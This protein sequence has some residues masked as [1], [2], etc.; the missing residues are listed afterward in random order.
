[1]C[2][3][4]NEQGIRK[5]QSHCCHSQIGC[6]YCHSQSSYHYCHSQIANHYCHSACHKLISHTTKSVTDLRAAFWGLHNPSFSAIKK[7]TKVNKFS[8]NSWTW[9]ST[10]ARLDE[11]W[12]CNKYPVQKNGEELVVI[13]GYGHFGSCF[14]VYCFIWLILVNVP[15]LITNYLALVDFYFIWYLHNPS[16]CFNATMI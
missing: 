7:N 9:R 10:G 4:D 15:I 5:L 6:H 11:L 12:K 8:F 3:S 1:M 2:T 16:N 14:Y 13:S